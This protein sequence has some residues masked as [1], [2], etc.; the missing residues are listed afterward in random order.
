M[1]KLHIPLS[2]AQGG[3]KSSLL[4]ELKSRGYHVDGFRVSRAVQAQLGWDSLDRVMDSPKTMMEFQ[5][6]VFAQKYKNDRALR[7]QSNHVTLMERSFADIAAYSTTWMWKFVDRGDI[8]LRDAMAW[9]QEYV[10][11]C[12]AAQKEI[13]DGVIILPMMD[14]VVFENDPH[15]AKKEDVGAVFENLERFMDRSVFLGFPRLTITAKTTSERADQLEEWLR[16]L[17]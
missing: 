13:Y 6:E 9:L 1:A 4:N 8:S 10:R 16:T 17:M 3:G 2:G 11:A 15:R 14:H 5:Q 12:T 7:A